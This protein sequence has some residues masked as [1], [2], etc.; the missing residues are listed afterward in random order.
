MY[1]IKSFKGANYL[2]HNIDI[3]DFSTCITRLLSVNDSINWFFITIS[4]K[5]T[6]DVTIHSLRTSERNTDHDIK[7]SYGLYQIKYRQV[8]FY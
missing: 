5:L 3:I 2:I 4:I 1:F 6:S 8:T 7:V